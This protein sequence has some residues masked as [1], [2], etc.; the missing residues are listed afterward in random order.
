MKYKYI[1][2]AFLLLVGIVF[3]FLPRI[4]VS[5]PTLLVIYDFKTV[6]LVVALLFFIINISE[7]NKLIVL[8]GFLKVFLPIVIIWTFMSYV[9]AYITDVYVPFSIDNRVFVQISGLMAEIA[10]GLMLAYATYFFQDQT[11]KFALYG[12]LLVVIGVL[13]QIMFLGFGVHPRLYGLSGEAKGLALYVSPFIFPILFYPENKIRKYSVSLLLILI[14][15]GTFSATGSIALLIAVLI[16]LYLYKERI[17]KFMPALIAITY[18]LIL[19]GND[20]YLYDRFVGRILNYASADAGLDLSVQS[21]VNIPLIGSIGV[22]GNDAPA[23]RLLVDKPFTALFGVGIGMDTVYAYEY[24]QRFDSGFLKADYE[25]YITPNLAVINNL[26]NYGLL[27]LIIM[28]IG[29][30]KALRSVFFAI[31]EKEKFLLHFFAIH[32]FISLLV[33]DAIIPLITSYVF[34]LA[35]GYL[36]NAR[37]S[38]NVS[39]P[40]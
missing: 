27:L 1:A 6:V 7:L 8:V 34:L 20:A 24:L 9:F 5:V 3:N 25:G 22:E 18:F 31:T 35:L 36:L 15:I 17:N 28:T 26:L 13:W 30:L 19:L 40:L 12:L 39:V 16:S 2:F 38:Q 29:V 10:M 11:Y 23:L 21:I 32:Y 33:Y 4:G 14:L 37:R